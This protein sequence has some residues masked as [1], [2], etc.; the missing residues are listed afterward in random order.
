MGFR[1]TRRHSGPTAAQDLARTISIE[2]AAYASA[3]SLAGTRCPI[4]GKTATGARVVGR[5][6]QYQHRHKNT[7]APYRETTYCEKDAG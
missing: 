3:A 2:E 5:M 7:R 1:K 4:C 6:I